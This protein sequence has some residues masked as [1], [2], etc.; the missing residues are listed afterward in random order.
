LGRN[1]TFGPYPIDCRRN[2]EVDFL[3]TAPETTG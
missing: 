1:L 2:N 3:Q